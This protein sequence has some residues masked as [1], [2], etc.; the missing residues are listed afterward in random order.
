MT[1]IAVAPIK[2]VWKRNTKQPMPIKT[3]CECCGSDLTRTI[4]VTTDDRHWGVDC[5]CRA[6]G[7]PRTQIRPGMSLID[8]MLAGF[9][10]VRVGDDAHRGGRVYRVAAPPHIVVVHNRPIMHIVLT[11]HDG[12]DVSIQFT[13]DATKFARED[14]FYCPATGRAGGSAMDRRL[15]PRGSTGAMSDDAGA[16]EYAI[17]E[18]T[19]KKFG[20]NNDVPFCLI[21][22]SPNCD[23][24]IDEMVTAIRGVSLQDILD[25]RR[26]AAFVEGQLAD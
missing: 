13:G 12:R 25:R 23:I 10:H 6:I 14:V 24:D 15:R 9:S 18:Y 1:A 4:I 16:H 7:K 3:F 11:T 2:T 8:K 20:I 17:E 26:Q 19:R 21:T 5:Y 22:G